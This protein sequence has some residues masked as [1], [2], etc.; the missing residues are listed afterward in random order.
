MPHAKIA[1]TNE[2][3]HASANLVISRTSAT[4]AT[5]EAAMA[6]LIELDKGSER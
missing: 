5:A 2:T 6:Q 3:R 4:L 1:E